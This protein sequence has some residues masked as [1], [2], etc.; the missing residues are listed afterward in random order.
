MCITGSANCGKIVFQLENDTHKWSTRQL[1]TS[2][3]TV[4]GLYALVAILQDF[5][6][7]NFGSSQTV[8][9]KMQSLPVTQQLYQFEQIL[10]CGKSKASIAIAFKVWQS[11]K[12]DTGSIFVHHKLQLTI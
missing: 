9:S 2:L 10:K 6:P 11:L 12:Y 4:Q 1:T 5:F 7:C 8:L 3:Y